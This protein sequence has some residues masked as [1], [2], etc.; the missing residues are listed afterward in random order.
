M[1]ISPSMRRSPAKEI[2]HKRGQSFGSKLP[3]KSTDDELMLFN[4]MQRSERENFLLESS[5]IFHESFSKLSYCPDFKLGVNIAGRVES[6]DLL[7]VDGDKTDYDWLLTPPETPLF[8][9]LD[10]E[11]DHRIGL[12]PRGRA[13]TK[14]VSISRSSTMESTQRSR[15]SSASP[16]RLSP[17]PRANCGAAFARTRSSNSPSRCSPLLA[18]QPSAASPRSLTPPARNT[19]TPPRRSPS[20]VSRRV[21]TPSSG[22]TSNGTRGTSPVK[23]NRRSSLPKLQSWQLNDP[24]FSS[25]APPNLRTSLPDRPLSRSRGGSPSSF[26]GLDMGSRGSRRSMSPTPS[27]RASSSHSNERDRF[28]S[29]SK[30]SATS[31]GDDDLDCVQS[32]AVGYAGSS[33]VKNS[34]S[35]MTTKAIASSKKASKSFSPNSAPKRT[36]DSAVWLMDHRKAPQDMFRPLLSSVPTTTFG[37]GKGSNVH[38]PMLSRN[39]SVTTSSN[40]HQPMLSRVPTTS[41]HGATF[42]PFMEPDQ[43]R[44]YISGELE[45]T[46]SSGIHEDI[47]M[48]DKLDEQNEG[49]SCQQHS[50]SSIP[51]SP[52]ESSITEQY[53]KSCRW[54]LDMER[55][56]TANQISSDVLGSTEAG[57]GKLAT[58]A[59]CRK[60]F[61]AVN[62]DVDGCDYCEECASRD[63]TFST[64][65][66]THTTET[67]HQQDYK[68]CIAAP[69]CAEDSSE[70]S[71]DHQPVIN[72]PPAD[73]SQLVDTTEE[74]LLGERLKN[75]AEN[76]RP[77]FIEDSSLGHNNDIS[78]HRVNVGGYQPEESTPVEYDHFRDQNGNHN[79]EIS[80]CLPEICFQGSEFMSDITTGDCHK[81]TGSPSHK[82]NNA[83]GTGISV[84]PLQKSSSN[85]WPVVEGRPL[86]ATNILCSERYYTRDNDN[87]MRYILGRDSS[88][89]T[90]S[91]DVGC[92]RQLDISFE[93]LKSN[94]HG[95]VDKS[96]IGS[97][98]SR[99]SIAS[100]SDMSTSGS[101]VSFCPR[102]DVNVDAC[103]PTDN[104]EN[105]VSTMISRRENG[106]CKD[107][108][109]SAIECWSVA[110]AIASNDNEAVGDVVIR[111]QEADKMAHDDDLCANMSVDADRNCI[112]S[113]EEDVSAITSYPVEIPEHPHACESSCDSRQVQS[114]AVSA[115]D[116]TN[117]FDDCSVSAISDEGVLVSATEPK[118]EDLPN[119]EGSRKQ[120]QRSFT[121]EEATDTILFCSSIVHDLTYKAATIAMEHEQESELAGAPRPTVMQIGKSIR[122]EDGLLKLPHRQTPQPRVRKKKIESETITEIT[123]TEIIAK[124]PVAVHSASE[125][126]KA[127]DSMKP[128][129]MESKCNC[130]IM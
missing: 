128:P 78:S 38:R 82:V 71:L 104:S 126:T 21:I 16:N 45:A 109:S 74:T 124:D 30:A 107:A 89:A 20:P 112:R 15:R 57:H 53:V 102:S 110:Q 108:L 12:A 61:N 44:H 98:V 118:I 18:P 43:E 11:E 72:E 7:N 49:P 6:R 101:S 83:E 73:S 105:D 51:S 103:C 31:S 99:Q 97:N 111:N 25:D 93:R 40:V 28:S 27:R 122:R 5:D 117:M 85:K 33:A 50:L 69:H 87:T 9:S 130:T 91:I 84:F 114:E 59:R 106:S 17:S 4:D 129:K 52:E 23:D 65:H 39:S 80:R 41:E 95:D 54:D 75:L 90:S 62:V 127:S 24:G 56:R 76:N 88:S 113:Q 8:R 46:A 60:L 55:S 22:L 119:N 58:C 123:K 32:V 68:A 100:V 34:L 36:F 64:N 79:D 48:F 70:A 86:A 116:E 2:A 63:G 14:P 37:A 94:Q 1:P 26:S 42:G 19:L 120:I 77:H 96:Q 35:V 3:A 115:S 121:L 125:V 47:F 92:S 13:Q 81:S 67:P 66:E 10:N 29:C